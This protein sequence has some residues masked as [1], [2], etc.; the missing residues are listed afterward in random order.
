MRKIFKVAVLVLYVCTISRS[1]GMNGEKTNFDTEIG[2]SLSGPSIS[3]P[4]LDAQQSGQQSELSFNLQ[5]TEAAWNALESWNAASLI[6][7]IENGA[8][9]NA[10]NERGLPMIVSACN[11]FKD[12]PEILRV[13]Q[14]FIAKGANINASSNHL[15]ETP[16]TILAGTGNIDAIELLIKAGADINWKTLDGYSPLARAVQKY[17]TFNKIRDPRKKQYADMVTRLLG[18]GANPNTSIPDSNGE[19]GS[20]ITLMQFMARNGVAA[21]IKE[22]L[23]HGAHPDSTDRS[24][25]PI[26]FAIG[27][28]QGNAVRALVEGGAS[29]DTKDQKGRTPLRAAREIGYEGIA[30]YLEEQAT[31]KGY[32]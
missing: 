14:A 18:L 24:P 27:N 16:L 32:L 9:V 13:L 22:F 28:G 31:L 12:K 3:L 5:A 8:D 26:F 15:G 29:L 7:A 20:C 6:K 17:N 19:S 10:Q 23:K 4:R 11:K 21:M 25:A 30:N 1:Y 2:F